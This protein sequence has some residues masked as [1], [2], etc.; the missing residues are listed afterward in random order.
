MNPEVLKPYLSQGTP[1]DVLGNK[2]F[3]VKVKVQ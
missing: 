2:E 3:Q 1:I